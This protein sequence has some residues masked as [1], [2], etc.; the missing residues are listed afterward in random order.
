MLKRSGELC[1]HKVPCYSGLLTPGEYK[2]YG[3]A[4]DYMRSEIQRF[5]KRSATLSEIEKQI[6]ALNKLATMAAPQN[7]EIV[8]MRNEEEW[9]I[10][11]V[12]HKYKDQAEL[13]FCSRETNDKRLFGVIEKFAP[14]TAVKFCQGEAAPLSVGVDHSLVLKHFFDVESY[15]TELAKRRLELNIAEDLFK[16]HPPEICRRVCKAIACLYDKQQFIEAE[17]VVT[18][19]MTVGLKMKL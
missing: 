1:Q 11:K 9:Q 10:L 15:A 3:E 8:A 13:L 4:Y 7:A 19:R 16:R 5:K 14:E 2:A 17:N 12:I 6:P 18:K